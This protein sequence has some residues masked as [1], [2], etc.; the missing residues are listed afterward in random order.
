MSAGT[1][2]TPAIEVTN[3]TMAYGEKVIQRDLSFTINQGDVFVIM[4]E[5]GCGKSTLMRHLIGLKA[6]AEGRVVYSGNIDF[7]KAGP[8]V[9]N[10]IMRRCGV[11]YQ[12]GALW[13]SMTLGENVALPL[14]E[15]T[16][17][18]GEQVAR[19]VSLKLALVGLEGYEDL[20]PAELSGGMQKRAGLARAMALDPDFLFFDELSAGLDPINARKLDD[21]VLELRKC[22]GTT[23]VLV[24]H[25]LPSIFN[26]G[27]NSVFLDTR[28]KT[29]IA[30]GDPNELLKTSE[31]PRVRAFLTRGEEAPMS[32]KE[33]AHVLEGRQTQ[34]AKAE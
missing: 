25:E 29:I 10:R 20:Y 9:R 23:V 15:Y 13:S 1:N 22:L 27:T 6:P 21:L 24:T 4:G 12:H 11:L 18:S 7:W 16:D 14:Q 3:L 34:G 8:E 33:T 26:I 19:I 32:R 28:S 31:H 17:L 30:Q 2:R 5:S